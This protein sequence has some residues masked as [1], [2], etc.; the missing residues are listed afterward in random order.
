M[1]RFMPFTRHFLGMLLLLVGA[2]FPVYGQDT[3]Q[4]LDPRLEQQAVKALNEAFRTPKNPRLATILSAVLPG[5]G[6]VYNEKP[7][8]VPILYGGILT[9]TYFVDFNGRRFALFRDALIAFDAEEPNQFP[10]LNRDGLVRNVNFWRRNRDTTF[11]IYLVIYVLNIADAN[12][13]AHLSGFDVSEDL[14]FRWEPYQEISP[15]GLPHVGLRFKIN[16]N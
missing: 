1:N 9:N 2:A 5:A 8:K 7:W 3:L 10:N 12:V 11:L 6:Q 13:D 14:S 16:I 4:R 15:L